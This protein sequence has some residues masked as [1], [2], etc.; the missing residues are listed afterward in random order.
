[1]KEY[2][3]IRLGQT[4]CYLIPLSE[5]YLMIDCG[6]SG[7]SSTLKSWLKRHDMSLSSIQYLF[8]TH[9]HGDHC[10]L[11][12]EL[13][14]QN[15]KLKVILSRL[16][17]D[18]LATGHNQEEKEHFATPALSLAF[19]IFEMLGLKM[20]KSFPPFHI[21]PQDIIIDRD[22]YDL[23]SVVESEIKVLSAPGHTPDSILLIWRQNAFVGDA[24]RNLLNFLGAPYE[25][26][27]QT[28]PSKCRQSLRRLL[29]YNITRLHPGHGSSLSPSS[30]KKQAP[31]ESPDRVI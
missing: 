13:T 22:N 1:M 23:T 24:A 6:S 5:G 18:Y 16:C 9:H 7:D 20:E 29:K 17:A 28:D 21:R 14:S 26:I 19:R 15:P 3:R 11:L 30:L 12:N 27:C 25:P 31:D 2:Y 4:N 8:L 10:G